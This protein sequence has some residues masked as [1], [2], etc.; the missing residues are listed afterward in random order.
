QTLLEEAELP[1]LQKDLMELFASMES[2]AIRIRNIVRS[3]KTFSR[4]DEQG[5]KY[6]DLHTGIECCINLLTPRLK[7][8][9]NRKHDIQITRQY[10]DLPS[11]EC[12]S[13]QINQV[14]MHL[15]SNAIDAI[16]CDASRCCSDAP[17]SAGHITISTY[18]EEEDWAVVEVMDNGPG[19][20]ESIQLKLFDPF[21]TTKPVGKGTGLGLSISYQIIVHQHHGHIRW[22]AS[23]E[24]GTKFAFKIP[25][26]L[27]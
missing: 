4:L 14:V 23:P 17:Q 12:H 16:D 22:E 1:F 13:D 8:H 27:P 19:I 18:V 21:F 6:S 2:G 3:L 11:V 25:V 9:T 5:I 24:A 15:V 7:A 20:E 10:G 26:K